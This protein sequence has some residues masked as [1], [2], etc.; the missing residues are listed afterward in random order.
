MAEP[1]LFPY[2]LAPTLALA[3]VSAAGL[4]WWR[5]IAT[6]LAAVWLNWWVHIAVDARWSLWLILIGQLAVLGWLG[7]PAGLRSSGGDGEDS[8]ETVR[9]PPR[10]A[11]TGPSGV[12][13]TAGAR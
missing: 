8:Q 7:W 13:S 4:S 9:K 10:A 11:T 3:A 5:L 12:K 2:F 6:C 1:E